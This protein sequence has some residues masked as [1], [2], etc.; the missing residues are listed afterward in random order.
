[1]HQVVHLQ[2]FAKSSTGDSVPVQV[3]WSASGGTVDSTG[4]FSASQPGTYKIVG[5]LPS[6]SVPPDTATISVLAAMAG[7][8]LKPDSATL[9]P[10]G[11]VSFTVSG[12]LTDGSLTSLDGAVFSATGG[13]ITS[14]GAY[15]AGNQG[16]A[17]HVVATSSDGLFADTSTVKVTA[18][19]PTPVLQAIEISPASVSLQTKATQQFGVIGRMSDGKTVAVSGV[20][21]TATGGTITSAGGYTAGTSAGSYRV[22]AKLSSTGFADTATVKISLPPITAIVLTPATVSLSAGATQEFSVQG[23]RSDGSTAPVSASFTATGGTITSGGAFT[24]G[25]SGG[26]F[27]VIAVQSGATLADTSA[28]TISV[29]TTSPPPPTSPPP[30][31]LQ[32]IT[33]SPASA[34][35]ST[36]ATQQFSASGR[37]SDGTTTSITDATWTASGG[38]VS[39][40]GLY[41]AG[42]T[43]GAFRVIAT[44]SGKADTSAI[45]LTASAPTLQAVTLTPAS[46]SLAAGATQQ[47]S[48]AGKMSDGSTTSITGATWTATGGTVSTAGLYTAGQTA[49]GFRVIAAKSGKADTAAVTVT[50][51]A[52]LQSISITPSTAT[53]NTGATRQFSVSGKMSDGSTV[54]VSNP[55]WTATGGTVS[56]GGLYTAGGTAGS[57]SVRVTTSDGALSASANVMVVTPAP[58]PPPPPAGGGNEPGGFS[59]IAEIA[60]SAMPTSSLWS[61]SGPGVLAGCWFS[62]A[63]HASTQQDATAP[64]SPSGVYQYEWPAGIPV[65]SS[66]GILGIWSSP[67]RDQY[68]QVYESGWF[69]IP[70]P[71]LEV[72][73]TV[74]GMKLLGFWSVGQAALTGQVGNQIAGFIN[75]SGVQQSFT[76]D[77]RQQ[78]Q[79]ARAMSQNVNTGSLIQAGRWIRYEILMTINDIGAANGTLK[80]WING[81]QTHNYSNVVW[82]TA[83]APSLFFGR[84]WDPTWGGNGNV[85]NKARND[86][87]WIDH[88]YISAVR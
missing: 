17:Y 45:T 85:P 15:T 53:V 77:I 13:T 21:F 29:P 72:P 54:S 87:L 4:A 24:A 46:V 16:G 73:Q 83:D 70:S 47:Y 28:V 20:A 39:T 62:T 80:V 36:G 88:V 42:Q 78:N 40:G 44:K 22:V 8:V 51:P 76:L 69:K 12:R 56:S 43:V 37:M 67:S 68:S 33:I 66:D 60:F 63:A 38:T 19:A 2:A 81:A 34:S 59:R 65:G 1:M 61:C 30:L 32:S 6:A 11:T 50:A 35:L 71:D 64:K 49:G 48:V 55:T 23:R 86:F 7:V 57:F 14:A 52:T 9:Q 18:A 27:R 26:T 82:R 25:Q 10:G 84:L 41:T 74:G 75:G 79:V 5:T 58:P 3:K 31:T